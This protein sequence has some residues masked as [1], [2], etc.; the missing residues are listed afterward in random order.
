MRWC[1]A[2]VAQCEAER[3]S[4]ERGGSAPVARRQ[5]RDAAWHGCESAG[6]TWRWARGHGEAVFVPPGA[7]KEACMLSVP[8]PR[9]SA[10]TGGGRA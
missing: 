10:V 4:I 8:S 9:S 3:G 6:V 7:N 5:G 2:G 1:E